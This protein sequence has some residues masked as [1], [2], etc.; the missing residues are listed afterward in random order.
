VF[1]PNDATLLG[2]INLEMTGFLESLVALRG[3]ESY[4]LVCNTSNN[5]AVTRNLKQ[6]IVDLYLIPVDAVDQIYINATVE[7]SG[8]N[9]NQI[10]S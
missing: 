3:I 4:N 10:T 8:A 9:L 1:E 6:V 7:S 2:Q 5:T